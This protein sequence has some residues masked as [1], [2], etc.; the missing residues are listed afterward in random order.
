M[1]YDENIVFLTEKNADLDHR[2]NSL[3]TDSSNIIRTRRRCDRPAG[4][5]AA[6]GSILL[7][8]SIYGLG[9]ALTPFERE[10]CRLADPGCTGADQLSNAGGVLDAVLS[11]VGLVC[12]SSPGSS[13]PP[14]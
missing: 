1:G 2:S 14:P 12:S 4:G 7:G 8:V 9:D 6:V 5:R 13:S 10:T 3:A 11:L